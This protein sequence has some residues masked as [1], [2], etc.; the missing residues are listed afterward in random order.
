MFSYNEQTYP[1]NITEKFQLRKFN[2]LI[3]AIESFM[4]KV[5]SSLKA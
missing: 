5:W 4:D 2:V 3:S 1:R